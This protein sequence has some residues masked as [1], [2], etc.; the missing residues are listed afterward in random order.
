V[1]WSVSLA[2]LVL[3]AQLPLQV[4]GGLVVFGA[5]RALVGEEAARGYLLGVAPVLLAGSTLL[6][7]RWRAG[8]GALAKLWGPRSATWRDVGAGVAHGVAAVAAISY[9]LGFV[10]QWLTQLLDRDLPAVQEQVQELARSVDTAAPAVIALVVLAP[11]AEELFFRG[12]LFQAL[13]RRV[14]RWPAIGVSALLFGLVHLEPLV[15]VTSFAV[16]MYLAWLLARRETLVAPVVAHVVF[17]LVG[18]VL[19]RALPA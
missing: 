8:R 3:L 6:A 5:L 10:L 2:L 18:V 13:R 1:P 4:L 12:L 15:I 9:G 19:I 16:G 14:H 7:V 11:L 17:N